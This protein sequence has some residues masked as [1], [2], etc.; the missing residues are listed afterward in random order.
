[1]FFLVGDQ[2]PGCADGG[3]SFV[4]SPPTGLSD[5]NSQNPVVSGIPDTIVYTVTVTDINGCVST[6]T[7]Q[8]NAIGE[9]VVGL[10]TAFSPNGDGYNDFYARC[11]MAAAIWNILLSI[12]AGVSWYLKATLLPLDGTAC[13]TERSRAGLICGVCQSQNLPG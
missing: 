1:M 11:W 6:D 13:S 8:V 9:L 10:P 7:V 4:W 12:T 5:P 3:I 2:Y